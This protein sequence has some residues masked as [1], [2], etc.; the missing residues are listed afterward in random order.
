MLRD[1]GR[2]L[3]KQVKPEDVPGG[4]LAY[5]FGWA[6]LIADA[7]SLID[8]Q[9][10]VNRRVRTI[11][12]AR[13]GGQRFRRNLLRQKSLVKVG[14]SILASTSSPS[15]SLVIGEYKETNIECWFTSR[16][17][18]KDPSPELDRLLELLRS[19][20]LTPLLALTGLTSG[21]TAASIWEVIP[22]SWLID[23]FVDVSS[24]IDAYANS[25]PYE[26]KDMNIMWHEKLLVTGKVD[27]NTFSG[28]HWK[29]S[30]FLLEQKL[31]SVRYLS[32][33]IP[34]AQ[35][36]LTAS[37]S[38]ILVALFTA[39]TLKGITFKL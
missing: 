10:E 39:R 19:P 11:I 23:Y 25:I 37:H 18:I 3:S 31:R 7:L 30:E 35:P 6:P 32:P 24:F 9:S 20:E 4:Y 27:S 33:V 13:S 22:W 34:S 5:K 15:R 8:F 26:F 12:E 29:K 2:V 21:P 1:L 17:V 38:A 14:S 36:F 28:L 16:M